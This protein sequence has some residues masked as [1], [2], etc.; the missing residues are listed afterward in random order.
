MAACEANGDP[1]GAEER[2][3]IW[4][5][6]SV[7]LFRV[8]IFVQAA[9]NKGELI[10]GRSAICALNNKQLSAIRPGAASGEEL[11]RD[12]TFTRAFDGP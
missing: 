12:P 7:R 11:R 6:L 10:G 3:E 4:V 2:F 5:T 8:G 9:E 1:L